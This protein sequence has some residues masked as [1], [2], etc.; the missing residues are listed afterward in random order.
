MGSGCDFFLWADQSDTSGGGAPP[1]GGRG[2]G[3]GGGGA[4]PGGGRGRGRPGSSNQH[5][6]VL[7]KHTLLKVFYFILAKFKNYTLFILF[8]KSNTLKILFVC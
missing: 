8:F 4:A 7:P 1:G 3:H 6:S 5:R 2:G